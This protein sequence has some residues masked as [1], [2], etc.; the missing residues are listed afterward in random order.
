MRG[1][2]WRGVG[3]RGGPWCIP[4]GD[5]RA[6]KVIMCLAVWIIDISVLK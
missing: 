1:G 5:R 6:K 3:V 4:D 2:G